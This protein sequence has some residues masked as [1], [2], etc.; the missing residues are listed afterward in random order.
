ML[1][2]SARAAVQPDVHACPVCR[3]RVTPAATL[4]GFCWTRRGSGRDQPDERLAD[5]HRRTRRHDRSL[6]PMRMDDRGIT[7]DQRLRGNLSKMQ[8][9][10]PGWRCL[11]E[12]LELAASGLSGRG[13]H[14]HQQSQ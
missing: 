14:A 1:A 10:A 9:R 3:R 4:C 12:P 5:R 2:L 8:G 7:A 13:M 6:E 11:E